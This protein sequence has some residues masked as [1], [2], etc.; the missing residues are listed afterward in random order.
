MIHKSLYERV[1]TNPANDANE[2]FIVTG[3]ASASFA[4]QHLRELNDER[5][6]LIIGMPEKRSDH[7]RFLELHDHYEDRFD[8]YY[9]TGSPPVHSKLYGWFNHAEPV[10]GYS[11]SANYSHN[12]FTPDKQINQMVETS[13]GEIRKFYGELIGRC[14]RMR[15]YEYDHSQ[16]IGLSP[17]DSSSHEA[18]PGGVKWML[19]RQKVRISFLERNSGEVPTRS[20]LNWGIP[21]GTA[22]RP[23][24]PTGHPKFLR[25]D[26]AYLSLKKDTTRG[27]F[28]PPKFSLVTDDGWT[29]DCITAQDD[30]KAIES[31]PKGLGN[32]EL[33]RYLRKRIGVVPNLESEL[34]PDGTRKGTLITKDDL[35]AYG[36]TDYT[37]EKLNEETFLLDL[38]V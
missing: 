24:K 25:Y 19:E 31:N 12:G 35:I 18:P 9:L 28:L 10:V 8:G 6:N 3:Y 1:L 22:R 30:L 37:L 16:M 15:E 34:R 2:L 33:G 38:S 20:G 23:F 17:I 13:P 4:E 21:D 14:V 7:L 36:R 26:D 5:V 32:A 11:G 29:M 27:R